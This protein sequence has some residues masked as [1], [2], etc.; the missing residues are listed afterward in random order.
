MKHI[1][2]YTDGASRGNPGKAAI[3]VV[4]C[5]EKE[6]E[7]KKFG[8]YL[9]DNLTNNDAEYMAVIF[10]FKK[11]KAVFGKKIAEV[12]EIE[13]RSDSELLVNQMNGKYK[14]ENEKIQKFFI[15]IWNLKVDFKGVKFK[16]IPRE[17]NREADRLA[18]EALDGESSSQ[19]LF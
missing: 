8:E 14:I 16:A 6:Q 12:S 19:K 3:G 2:I 10:A 11:F 7:I 9:G 1:I 18:N 4:F 13:I 5:N 15:E 17:K